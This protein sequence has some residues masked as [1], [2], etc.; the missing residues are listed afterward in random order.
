MGYGRIGCWDGVG[1]G[2]MGGWRWCDLKL[3]LWDKMRSLEEGR[4]R[5]ERNR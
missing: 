5:D 2:L 1:D 4:R 3:E